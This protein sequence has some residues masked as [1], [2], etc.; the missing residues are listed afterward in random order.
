MVLFL[1]R[2]AVVLLI[3]QIRFFMLIMLLGCWM[4]KVVV[5]GGIPDGYGAANKGSAIGISLSNG[6]NN[7]LHVKKLSYGP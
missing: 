5:C 1:G 6:K 7:K 2:G 3:L 4:M